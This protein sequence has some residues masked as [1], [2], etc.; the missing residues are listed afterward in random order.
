MS[1]LA[2]REAVAEELA[3]NVHPSS[4]VLVDAIRKRHGET[5]A[6]V[7]FYGSCLMQ[8]PANDPPEGIQD[9]Y[10]IVDRFQDAYGS[11]WQA[12]ANR[13]LPPNVFYIEEPFE[14]HI[15]RAKYAVVSREQFLKGTSP[16]AFHP[17]L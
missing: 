4:T 17:S 15:V 10:V 6:A 5:V 8:D 7:L 13:F 3:R 16:A 12:C 2:L 9:F 14:G 11:R 1:E